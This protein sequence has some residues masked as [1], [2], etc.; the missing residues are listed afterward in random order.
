MGVG[1]GC[2][3]L[4]YCSI[5]SINPILS[6][7]TYRISFYDWPGKQSNTYNRELD[8]YPHPP[9][10]APKL[11]S[12][13]PITKVSLIWLENAACRVHVQCSPGDLVRYLY[14]C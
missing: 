9:R 5:S 3:Y 6:L 10:P 4:R 13:K 8:I 11:D 2:L 12:Y 14:A 7:P 1:S